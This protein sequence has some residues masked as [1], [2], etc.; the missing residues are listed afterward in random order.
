MRDYSSP[1]WFERTFI[2]NE[3][4]LEM[5]C[6]ATKRITTKMTTQES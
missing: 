4:E 3:F 5:S 6:D 2:S 1:D